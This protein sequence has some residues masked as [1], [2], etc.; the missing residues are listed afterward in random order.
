MPQAALGQLQ[1]R[2]L[3]RDMKFEVSMPQAALGQLQLYPAG[4][5]AVSGLADQIWR[6]IQKNS[7]SHYF[8]TCTS[9]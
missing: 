2:M 6:E 7:Y 8:R 3:F 1:L 9:I 4:S 5:P